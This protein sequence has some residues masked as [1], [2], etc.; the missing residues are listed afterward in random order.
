VRADLATVS[1]I[2]GQPVATDLATLW[3]NDKSTT[4]NLI[5]RTKHPIEVQET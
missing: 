3:L 2:E 4:D 5:H 1:D